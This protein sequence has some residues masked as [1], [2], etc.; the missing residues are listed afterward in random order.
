MRI[1]LAVDGS[2]CSDAALEALVKQY[3]SQE[4]EV[5]VLSVVESMK[6]MPISYGFGAGP[7]FVQDYAEI[8]KQWRSDG[9]ALVA[10]MAEK[11]R[12]AGFTVNTLLDEGDA[13][14]Q[15]LECARNWKPD[16]IVLG[17]H[18]WRGLDRF[19]L[20]SVS[21]AIMRHATC[22]VEIVRTPGE[23]AAEAA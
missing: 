2:K 12:G 18:G 8:A 16:L 6:L 20:G 19:L 7:V 13:R 1:L 15:I 17:S 5:L 10:R 11:L 3:K 22:S 9:Q 14:E 4:T 23:A 21:D